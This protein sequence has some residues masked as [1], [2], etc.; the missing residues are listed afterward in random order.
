MA[1]KNQVVHE[2]KIYY[3]MAATARLLG[4]TTT[5]V[6]QLIVPEGLEWTNIRVNGPIWIGAES[7]ASYLKRKQAAK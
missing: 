5:K 4:T 1:A 3:S 7:I 6:K 2:G